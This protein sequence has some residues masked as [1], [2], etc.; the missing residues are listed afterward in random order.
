MKYLAVAL[1]VPVLLLNACSTT[2]PTTTKKKTVSLPRSK[3]ISLAN[4]KAEGN[5]R[6]VV[7]YALGLL[8]VDYQFGGSNPE[9]GLDCSGMASFIY[10]NALGIKLPHNAAEIAKRTREI[11][12]EQLRA[13]DFVFFNSM[14]RSYS[15]M[16]IYLGD[17]KFIHAPRTNSTIR[18][19]RLDNQYFSA[20]FDG[21]RTLFD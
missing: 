10:Q 14:N 13:G 4:I 12:V 21:A 15:H 11:R 5:A 8:D 16:G 2:H 7:M 18:V 19:E 1:L 17:G 20:R 3:N 6:E 9:A